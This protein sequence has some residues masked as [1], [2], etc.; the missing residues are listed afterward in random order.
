MELYEDLNPWSILPLW[1]WIQDWDCDPGK[2]KTRPGT[3]LT[4]NGTRLG[5]KEIS[6]REDCAFKTHE[7]I[8]DGRGFNTWIT[9]KKTGYRNQTGWKRLLNEMGIRWVSY[10]SG[11]QGCWGFPKS[12]KS[13]FWGKS[14]FL[15]KS[16]VFCYGSRGLPRSLYCTGMCS[17]HPQWSFWWLDKKIGKIFFRFSNVFSSFSW[18]GFIFVTWLVS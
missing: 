7:P 4:E 18:L 12:A 5:G 8:D 3:H 11:D 17:R 1:W 16:Q 2:R 10:Y 9:W 15:R 6:H 14:W 13:H